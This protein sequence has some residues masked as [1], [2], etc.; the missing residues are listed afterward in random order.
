MRT[1]AEELG[2]TADGY[3]QVFVSS[4]LT[5]AGVAIR[6]FF[7]AR[8]TSLNLTE[9]YGSEFS[10][11]E[12]G[13][14]DVDYVPLTDDSLGA[15]DLKPVALKEFVLANRDALLA[16]AGFAARTSRPCR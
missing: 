6:Y 16:E 7:V 5:D 9:R 14:Y 4:D 13:G 3:Q 11:P 15:I 12:R 1:L 8:L 2:A 10:K